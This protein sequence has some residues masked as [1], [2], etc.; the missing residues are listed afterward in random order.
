MKLIIVL[1]L[2]AMQKDLERLFNDQGVPVYSEVDIQGFRTSQTQATGWFGGK[3]L[4]VYSL[5]QFAF[6]PE[7]Q[8]SAFLEAVRAFNET[9]DEEHPVHA[10]QVPVEAFV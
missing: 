6:V 8:A 7:S 1:S 10:F 9:Q 5:M 4:G 3:N 2:E